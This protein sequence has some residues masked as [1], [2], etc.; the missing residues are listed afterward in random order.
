LT[1]IVDG[2][3]MM[4]GKEDPDWMD[5][6][7]FD[8]V[9]PAMLK[10]RVD[11]AGEIVLIYADIPQDPAPAPGKA[12]TAPAPKYPPGPLG[13]LPLK[14]GLRAAAIS[15]STKLPKYLQ[16]GVDLSIY[17]FGK[18]LEAK[19]ELPPK[20]AKQLEQ[21]ATLVTLARPQ[22]SAALEIHCQS[23]S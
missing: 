3:R 21:P 17:T 9:T 18:P 8:W 20:I 12:R 23:L 2:V 13:G 4:V 22:R 14:P 10:G 15:E 1:G 11:I 5:L 6:T 16:D 19:L 7:E